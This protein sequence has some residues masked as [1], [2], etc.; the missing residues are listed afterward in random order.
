MNHHSMTPQIDNAFAAL[1]QVHYF[2]KLG[3]REFAAADLE[4]L[5]QAAIFPER[6]MYNLFRANVE[7][8]IQ[9]LF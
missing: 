5:A 2:R 7:K 4:W 3:P 1:Q 8:N 6:D 9:P